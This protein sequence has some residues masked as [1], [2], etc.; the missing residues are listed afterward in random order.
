MTGLELAA[1]KKLA[2][3]P[4]S[5]PRLLLSFE[6]FA[7]IAAAIALY[8]MQ[9]FNGW[10]FALLLL[11]PDISMAA[12]LVNP[13]VGALIYNLVHFYGWPVLLGVLSLF[14]GWAV[15]LQLAL[16]WLAHIG[17]DRLFGYGYK[18]PTEFKDTHLGRI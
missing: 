10:V 3:A 18:Y 4:I 15:I 11:V 8:A 12:Y 16:I 7:V 6:G 1:E 14:F 2:R 9:G 5:M 13:R 17:M